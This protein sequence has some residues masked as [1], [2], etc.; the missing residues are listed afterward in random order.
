MKLNHKKIKFISVLIVILSLILINPIF[1]NKSKAENTP[2]M[3]NYNYEKINDVFS[4]EFI[5]LADINLRALNYPESKINVFMNFLDNE[6]FWSIEPALWP[7]FKNEKSWFFGSDYIY[8]DMFDAIVMIAQNMLTRSDRNKYIQPRLATK[9]GIAQKYIDRLSKKN[10]IEYFAETSGQISSQIIN[11]FLP[12]NF[13]GTGLSIPGRAKQY[14]NIKAEDKGKMSDQVKDALY[15]T[16]GILEELQDVPTLLEIPTESGITG[17]L[18]DFASQRY[19]DANKFSDAEIEVIHGYA[20]LDWFMDVSLFLVG[21]EAG[22]GVSGLPAI[23]KANAK[24]IP[25][26]QNLEQKGLIENAQNSIAKDTLNALN[27]KAINA[28]ASEISTMSE[29]IEKERMSN[30]KLIAESNEVSKFIGTKVNAGG[31]TLK[32]IKKTI[33]DK[34]PN[35]TQ[36][37]NNT[38]KLP[39][40]F[41]SLENPPIDP[42]TGQVYLYGNNAD[43]K[44]LDKAI[45]IFNTKPTGKD[46]DGIGKLWTDGARGAIEKTK[47]EFGFKVLNFILRFKDAKNI[48][49]PDFWSGLSNSFKPKGQKYISESIL[50]HEFLEKYLLESGAGKDAFTA[51]FGGLEKKALFSEV[52]I[53]D[54]VYDEIYYRYY[55]L[56]GKQAAYEIYS[57]MFKTGTSQLKA[58]GSLK[59]Y[60]ELAGLIYDKNPNV[61]KYEWQEALLLGNNITVDQ[62]LPAKIN[63]LGL[64]TLK[65]YGNQRE[66]FIGQNIQSFENLW[67]HVNRT[68]EADSISGVLP[69]TIEP[70]TVEHIVNRIKK[71]NK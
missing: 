15:S 71:L 43:I 17:L 2:W 19:K 44:R 62:R 69:E 63:R 11:F 59:S 30:P 67:N 12:T 53:N 7:N 40:K 47:G 39:E 29:M 54:I 22:G 3:P 6:K 5:G 24:K 66:V 34:Y 60:Y 20:S 57:D 38:Y 9:E 16:R 4:Q 32:T 36:W 26:V 70:P 68:M 13:L 58:L 49:K 28:E 46:I 41:T 45:R 21:I 14:I 65:K 42:D 37:L 61:I 8:S 35:F 56:L 25:V 64:D 51:L 1:L 27:P 31:G 18:R 23:E 10:D 50:E 55:T 48:M 52:I 33:M